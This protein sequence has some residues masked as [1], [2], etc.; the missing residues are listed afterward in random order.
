MIY[1]PGSA[2]ILRILIFNGLLI[3]I[4]AGYLHKVAEQEAL[5]HTCLAFRPST[6]AGSSCSTFQCFT[7]EVLHRCSLF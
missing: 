1:L 2:L 6:A 4:I 3:L 7:E 5:L